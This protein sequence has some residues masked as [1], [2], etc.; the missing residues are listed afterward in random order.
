MLQPADE[1]NEWWIEVNYDRKSNEN[2]KNAE[3]MEDLLWTAVDTCL[4]RGLTTCV[5]YGKTVNIL[6][7]DKTLPNQRDLS[8]LVA[9][10]TVEKQ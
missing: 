5:V 6:N 7:N 4:P 10:L 8:V 2:L 1:E 3:I 9:T